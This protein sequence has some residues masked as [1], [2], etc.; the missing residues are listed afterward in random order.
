MLTVR[1][2]AESRQALDEFCASN[3][4]TITAW[5]EAVGQRLIEARGDSASSAL[6]SEVDLTVRVARRIDAE[7]R[8]RTRDR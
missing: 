5:I 8:A 3:G 7:R 1:I 4:I 2:S 6:R